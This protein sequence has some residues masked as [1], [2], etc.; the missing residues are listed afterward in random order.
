[1]FTRTGMPKRAACVLIRHMGLVLSVSRKHDPTAVGLP[2]GK[3]DPG[4]DEPTAAVRELEEET[5]LRVDATLLRPVFVRHADDEEYM[6]TTFEV[7]WHDCVGPIRTTEQ[8]R[9]RWVTW[10]E[11]LAGPFG[12]Y[13][14][15]LMQELEIA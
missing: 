14:A 1:M 8:G 15:M 11:L 13:N 10:D 3:V 4:E 6:T 7:D 9:V 2:G 12:R 5:G